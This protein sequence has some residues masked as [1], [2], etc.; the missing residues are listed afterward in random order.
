MGK[1]KR[2][3]SSCRGTLNSDKGFPGDRERG[4]P[5]ANHVDIKI[6]GS[7]GEG[8][9]Q[10][11]RTSVAL[12]SILDKSVQVHRI[13]H[14]RSKPGLRA[15]HS[16]GIRLVGNI[17]HAE[18]F[19]SFLGSSTLTFVPKDPPRAH[20]TAPLVSTPDLN[21][22]WT[23]DVGTAG[24][25]AL[26]LQAALPVAL[27]FLP[28]SE[29]RTQNA[30]ETCTDSKSPVLRIQ[31]GT[32][33]LFAPTGDYVKH[34]LVPNLRLFGIDVDFC[35]EKNGFFPRGG[36]SCTVNIDKTNCL[37][38]QQGDGK[39]IRT[40][41]PCHVTH[42]GNISEICGRVLVCS[43]QYERH[44]LGEEMCNG[45]L[46]TL[47]QFTE[48]N[49]I[50]S[51][52]LEVQI[53]DQ[54][55]AGYTNDK[56]LSITLWAK[57]AN[58]TTFGA[59]LIWSEADASKLI[60]DPGIME[61]KAT[62]PGYVWRRS[63]AYAGSVAAEE[64]CTSLRSGAA[65]DSYMADQLCIFMGMASG[66]SSLVVPPPTQHLLSVLDVMRRFGINIR[67]ED[68]VDSPNK[69]LVCDGIAVSLR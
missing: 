56:H 3:K 23:C 36:G 6:D 15:Q 62:D 67:L 38:I 7:L 68:I 43:P 4:A 17:C 59:S 10:I 27:R 52:S 37:C 33:A 63:A 45:A 44:G 16:S 32:T 28:G 39:S 65:V 41:R 22:C 1:R 47:R 48:D 61:K 2:E 24:A 42:G 46:T 30:D 57:A 51:E 58:Q 55:V 26:V 64:L 21:Q 14:G 20:A 49:R 53:Y 8:G 66:V 19:G 54:T 9:G 12:S 25:T 13:R 35:V 40:L 31:G 50:F 60:N 18:V 5:S 11:I 29:S 69:L 34:V